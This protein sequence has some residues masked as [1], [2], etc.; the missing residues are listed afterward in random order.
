M[1]KTAFLFAV[2]IFVTTTSLF[3]QNTVKATKSGQI[4]ISF[5]SFGSNDVF[6]FQTLEG[7][8]SYNADKFYTLGINYLYPL[9]KTFDIE[10]AF[11]YSKHYITIEPNLPPD[12]D[13]SPY[14]A[15]FSV[16][17]IPVT[18]RINFLRHFFVNGGLM[19]DI[20]PTVSSPVDSQSG[21]G[22]IM[23]LGLKYDS[24]SGI[25]VFV[26]PYFKAHALISFLSDEYPQHLMESGFRFGVMYKLK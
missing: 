23:G 22:A 5:S 4:G 25:A 6:S 17:N 20:D 11:E 16:I 18:I 3:A 10:T 1:K 15:E 14:G 13:V 26:N 9:N 24:K 7:A 2:L 21:I 8:A 12:M 19:M